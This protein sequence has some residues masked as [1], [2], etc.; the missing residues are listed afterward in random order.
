MPEACGK[1]ILEEW[2]QA[3]SMN[4]DPATTGEEVLGPKIYIPQTG[5]TP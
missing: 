1:G 5:R 3:M 2:S 4:G